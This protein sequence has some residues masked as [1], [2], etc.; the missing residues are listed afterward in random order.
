MLILVAQELPRPRR[1]AE[2]KDNAAGTLAVVGDS[3]D[4]AV[5]AE[6]KVG[7]GEGV[8]KYPT[9]FLGIELSDRLKKRKFQAMWDS[10]E[11]QIKQQYEEAWCASQCVHLDQI[12]WMIVITF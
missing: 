11:P 12:M 5:D 4:T 9:S 7:V 3:K 1:R 2:P 8:D 6:K 10:I